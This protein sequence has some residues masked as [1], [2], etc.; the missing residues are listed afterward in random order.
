M[1]THITRMAAALA[2]G[3]LAFQAQ[4]AELKWQTGLPAAQALAAQENK[5]VFI[6][7]TGSD[8]CG[9]CVKLNK[10]VFNTPEFAA[11]AAKNLVLVEADFPRKKALDPALKKAN[12]ALAK[13]YGVSGF[14]TLVALDAK[15]KEVWRNVGYLEGGPQAMI[16]ALDKA[17]GR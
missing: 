8:W 10:E 3:W 9:W 2:A 16:R 15:G 1:N 12:D 14:P 6:D 5:T 7:F 13:K 17:R 11:Y 4:A